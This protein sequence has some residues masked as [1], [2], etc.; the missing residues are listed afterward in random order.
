MNIN[1]IAVNTKTTLFE[2]KMPA[3]P[4]NKNDALEKIN[5]Q[6]SESNPIDQK[7]SFSASEA[8][9]MVAEMNEIMTDLQTRL[10]FSI[11]EDL[12]NQVII[13]ITDRET[14]ELIKQIP[15]EELLAFKGK[16]E[17]FSGL[18]FDQKI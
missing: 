10:G 11:R 8:K 7:D 3:S 18:I 15:S 1:N 13:E 17:E 2:I 14:N 6:V 9:Q 4:P 5:S 12:N 16:M